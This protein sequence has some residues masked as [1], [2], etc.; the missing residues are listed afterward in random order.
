MVATVLLYATYFMK[1]S[2]RIS[3][4]SYTSTFNNPTHGPG[5]G[6]RIGPALWVL[7]SCLMFQC[8][9]SLCQGAEFCDPS[10]QFSHQ[11]MGDGFINDVRNVFN[12]GIATMLAAHYS[13]QMIATGMQSEAQTWKRLLWSTGGALELFKCFY[14]IVS[15]QFH[16]NETPILLSPSEMEPI[17][18]CLTSGDNHNPHPIEHK[19]V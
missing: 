5:Q 18:I 4:G 17:N 6:S 9:E 14:Y 10:Q 8:M 7:I 13:E 2:H 1:T 12:F 16:K 11:R 3:P 19:S 15:W